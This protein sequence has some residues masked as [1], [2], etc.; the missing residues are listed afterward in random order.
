M[1][2]FLLTNKNIEVFFLSVV[3]CLVFFFWGTSKLSAANPICDGQFGNNCVKY[4]TFLGDPCSTPGPSCFVV[5]RI[6][7]YTS[8]D[9]ATIACDIGYG[10]IVVYECPLGYEKEFFLDAERDVLQVHIL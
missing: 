1:R 3:G 9:C 6:N 8:Y 5:D 7:S 2:K 10:G 4:E